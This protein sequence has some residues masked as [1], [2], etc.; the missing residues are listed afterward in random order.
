M[1]FF[2]IAAAAAILG[3][4]GRPVQSEPSCNELQKYLT[5]G[6]QVFPSNRGASLPGEH[7]WTARTPLLNGDCEITA[8]FT[9]REFRLNC[10]FN[11]GGAETVRVSTQ[12][13]LSSY[14]QTC[15]NGLESRDDWRKRDTS[16]TE[17]DGRVITETRWTW[18]MLRN[19][20]ERQILVSNDSGG[21]SNGENLLVVI[22]RER[23]T[24]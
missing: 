1:A 12:Q 2:R 21:P 6:D 22:W 3:L 9:P 10:R 5:G 15:L 16:R 17:F 7:R 18:T 19:R 13:S 23:P 11:P 14:V 20:I 8:A 24:D 4:L